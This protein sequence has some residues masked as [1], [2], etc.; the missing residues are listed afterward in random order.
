[1]VKY[2]PIKQ[3]Q[4]ENPVFSMSKLRTFIRER[5]NNGFNTVVRKIG[6]GWFVI[7]GTF[8][9]WVDKFNQIGE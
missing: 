2:I 7:D 6:G 4:K 1:M 9:Q 3:W 5:E 8:D